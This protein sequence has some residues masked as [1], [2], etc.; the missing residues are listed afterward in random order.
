MVRRPAQART[1]QPR[2]PKD[3]A[4]R[5]YVVMTCRP[6]VLR[7]TPAVYL[8]LCVLF[9]S[10]ASTGKKAAPTRRPKKKKKNKKKT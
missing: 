5:Y 3:G 9:V 2:Q 10:R 6:D 1:L 8:C 7:L 4:S